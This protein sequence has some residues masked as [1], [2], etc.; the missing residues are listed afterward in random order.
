MK[1]LG[2]IFRIFSILYPYKFH[3]KLLSVRDVCYTMWI[4]NFLG[5]V[6]EHSRICYPCKL[7]GGGEKCIVIGDNTKIRHNSLLGCYTNYNKQ[8]FSNASITIGTNCDIGRNIHITA[9]NKITIGNGVLTGQYVIISDNSHGGMSKEESLIEPLKRELKSKGE[10]I[11][12][13]NVWIGD[14][15]SIL[16]DVHIGSNVIIGAN[17]VVTKDIPD[18]CIA[19]GVPAKIIKQL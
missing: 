19:V 1:F 11:I 18:N 8:H 17:S 7:G 13:D 4:K 9:C 14:K 6:G 16:A 3:L 5:N 12:G 15:V 10:V 2:I